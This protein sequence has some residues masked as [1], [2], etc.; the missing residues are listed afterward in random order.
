MGESLGAL[1]A[2]PL[3]HPHETGRQSK[4]LAWLTCATGNCS[5]FPR[6]VFHGRR[7]EWAITRRKQPFAFLTVA[8]PS[9]THH[10]IRSRPRA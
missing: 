4:D 3:S 7:V 6:S 8:L 5:S 2:I 9:Q 10:L 1:V